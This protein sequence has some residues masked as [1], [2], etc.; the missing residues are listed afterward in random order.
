MFSEMV[1]ELAHG[2]MPEIASLCRRFDMAI[3]KKM[4]VLRLPAPFWMDDPKINPR[5]DHLFWA[6]LLLLDQERMELARAVL[7]AEEFERQGRIA[8]E[9]RTNP[10]RARELLGSL[11]DLIGDAGLRQEFAQSLQGVA[12]VWL[13]WGDEY[14]A[15]EEKTHGH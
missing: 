5:A 4:G 13:A 11:L 6:S 8:Q 7:V 14:P 15:G 10:E 9:R 2:R 3:T 1:N 12:P